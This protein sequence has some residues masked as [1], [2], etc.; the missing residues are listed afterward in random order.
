M[1]ICIFTG[2]TLPPAEAGKFLDA[3][4]L[5]PAAIGDVYSAACREPWAIGII[6]G[7][8]ENV[9]SVWHKEIL[10]AMAQGI[11]VFGAASM[12]ALRA[13]E[14]CAFGM[15][16]V[17]RIFE[18]YRDGEIEDDD[19][20]AVV[21]GPPE[22]GYIQTSEA[23][24]NIRA[25]L[26]KATAEDV[27][28]AP[29]AEALTGFAKSLYYKQRSYDRLL[30][31]AERLRLPADAVARLKAWLPANR[32]NQ[33]RLD[34]IEMLKEIGRLNAGDRARKEVSY[35]F[36]RT[37]FWVAVE[38]QYASAEPP[39]V[40]QTGT[41]EGEDLIEEVRLDP[42][43]FRRLRSAS[44]LRLL[45]RSAFGQQGAEPNLTQLQDA[46]RRF[47]KDRALRSAEE[48]D[49]WLEQRGL[50]R[51]GFLQMMTDETR[52]EALEIELAAP[53][54]RIMLDELRLGEDLA[55]MRQRAGHK[56]TVLQKRGIPEPG[57]SDCGLSDQQ[58]NEWILD[59]YTPGMAGDGIDDLAARLG[60]GD[61]DSLRR[62]ALRE[63]G[64]RLW[65][66]S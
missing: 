60:F 37:T 12:G 2:P 41:P 6:D 32:V 19:E 52:R 5:P 50:S 44:L 56:R 62:A 34:A 42:A 15:V 65:K 20:V 64:Y 16:G 51:D 10:W 29:D 17:G 63:Y 25:T 22:L 27:L 23:M 31:E 1:T 7:I 36:E 66:D 30:A 57:L 47:V 4:F 9:P 48:L 39:G 46:T 14:L 49:A 59:Q 61:A 18:A 13:A 3:E 55:A 28:S 11:H 53:L 58:L 45:M 24:V 8:F 43:L 21:H 35:R 38:R 40:G 33:K 54:D 26:H